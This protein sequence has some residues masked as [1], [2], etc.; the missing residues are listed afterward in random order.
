MHCIAENH[1]SSAALA[2]CC[3][4]GPKEQTASLSLLA[5]TTVSS[6]EVIGCLLLFTMAAAHIPQMIRS[7]STFCDSSACVLAKTMSSIGARYIQHQLVILLL[8]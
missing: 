3:C 5:Q 6:A 4:V 2:F 8:V 7:P 1:L